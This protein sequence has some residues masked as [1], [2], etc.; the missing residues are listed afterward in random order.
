VLERIARGERVAVL[1]EE[2]Q[3]WPAVIYR[4]KAQAEELRGRKEGESPQEKEDQEKRA[5]EKRVAELER[6]L[7][8]KALEV[9]FLESALRRV[10][11]ETSSSG[12]VG[13]KTSGPRSA[14]GWNRKA[15]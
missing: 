5:L 10:N 14:A 11:G 4:W 8:Q 7:G 6:A 15:D 1:A 13:E 9:D 2:F 3:L 12:A